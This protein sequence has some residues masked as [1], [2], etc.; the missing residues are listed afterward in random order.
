MD[1]VVLIDWLREF[2]LSGVAN[3]L[4]QLKQLFL[5]Y[6]KVCPFFGSGKTWID[7]R[8]KS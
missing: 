1:V 7:T 8:W 4:C 6:C 5:L 3:H 2:P